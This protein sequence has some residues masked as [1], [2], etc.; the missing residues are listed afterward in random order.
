MTTLSQGGQLNIPAYF[1][2]FHPST[3]LQQYNALQQEAS[4]LVQMLRG[5]VT[6]LSITERDRE[7][8]CENSMNACSF[9]GTE[10]V[11]RDFGCLKSKDQD[12]LTIFLQA[13]NLLEAIEAEKPP[14]PLR[15]YLKTATTSVF[16][17]CVAIP[18]F[19]YFLSGYLLDQV[20]PE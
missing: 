18:A 5:K 16:I 2:G 13:T 3:R 12:T 14:T 10:L 9:R 6:R 7:Q 4:G 17:Y 20:F 11:T 19:T 1:N 8:Q 15:T